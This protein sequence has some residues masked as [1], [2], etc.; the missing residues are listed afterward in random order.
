MIKFLRGD[1]FVS[2]CQAIVNPVN[3]VGVSGTGLAEA[4]RYRYPNN[5][6]E[7]RN[8]CL[9]KQLYPGK[10]LVVKTEAIFNPLYVINFPTKQHWRDP[11]K[12]SY[13]ED[14]IIEMLSVLSDFK[15][16]SVAIPAL[17]CGKGKLDWSDVRR[18]MED[19]FS[20]EEDIYFEI[21]EPMTR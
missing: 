14:G 11:S 21:Y 19:H 7:Y 8:L 15:I 20:K 5:F 12:L 4:L 9:R 6:A 3:C 18:L 13:V 16:K 17:G 10:L 1:I 2:D